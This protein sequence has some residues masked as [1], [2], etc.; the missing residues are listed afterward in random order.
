MS[1]EAIDEAEGN[2]TGAPGNPNCVL[3]KNGFT[4]YLRCDHCH[5]GIRQCLGTQYNVLTILIGLLLFL[6]LF[7]DHPLAVQANVLAILALIFWLGYRINYKTDELART[8]HENMALNRRLTNYSRSLEQEVAKRTEELHRMATHDPLTG[9][10][11]RYAFEQAVGRALGGVR[12]RG[13]RAV[14]AFL[15]LDQFKP[16]N[17]HCGHQAGDELLRQLATLLERNVGEHDLAARLGGDEFGVLFLGVELEEAE[18][19]A[20]NLCETIAALRFQWDDKVFTIGASIGLTELSADEAD[21]SVPL[22]AADAACYTAKELGRNRVHLYQPSDQ[23]RIERNLN[24]EWYSQ[25]TAALADGRF[26]PHAQPITSACGEGDDVRRYEMLVRMVGEGG[27]LIPPR[28]FIPTAERYNLMPEVD[29]WVI[30][31]SLRFLDA[32]NHRFPLRDHIITLNLAAGSLGD[33][34]LVPFLEERIREQGVDAESICVEIKETD[35]IAHLQE[36]VRL[37]DELKGA[38]VRVALDD[39]GSGLASFAYL[40]SLPVDHIKIDGSFVRNID[41]DEVTRVMVAAIHDIGQRMG[42]KTT[43]EFV[44]DE[45]A[46][47]TMRKIGVDFVQGYHLGRPKPAMELLDEAP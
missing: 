6:F 27:E 26:V 4:P 24:A 36:T 33:R 16:V 15:D 45:A 37:I 38:G 14:L 41:S 17:D 40:K 12:K 8:N 39:F 46:L 5:V 20:Q 11:N 44:E 10:L 1:E 2:L 30:A 34:E 31:E 29:R 47:E 13:E 9:L 23:E 42:I 7:I 35:A 21:L 32:L 19:R 28:A 3:A 18:A 43:G 25:I 22:K